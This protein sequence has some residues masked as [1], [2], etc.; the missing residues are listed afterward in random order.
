M[1]FSD[2]MFDPSAFGGYPPAVNMPPHMQMN[3]QRQQ[4]PL[5]VQ[6]QQQHHR[7]QARHQT[8]AQALQRL[9]QQRRGQA[10]RQQDSSQ[11]NQLFEE[12]GMQADW[13]S[14]FGSGRGVFQGL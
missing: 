8:P 5:T 9:Q 12:Q 4:T 6:Q 1:D 13:G 7:Q 10:R 2:P 14:F 3:M 11:I